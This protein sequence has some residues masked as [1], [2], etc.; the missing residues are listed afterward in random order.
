M[1][2]SFEGHGRQRY[3][4]WKHFIVSE[5]LSR[6]KGPIVLQA[7]LL[8]LGSSCNRVIELSC[9][10]PPSSISNM[11]IWEENKMCIFF[12]SLRSTLTLT[13]YFPGVSCFLLQSLPVESRVLGV[14]KAEGK[15]GWLLAGC[16]L[17]A[18]GCLLPGQNSSVLGYSFPQGGNTG[19]SG[20]CEHPPPLLAILQSYT[21]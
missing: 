12:C 13:C 20:F 15:A 21:F 7:H 14:P 1:N 16:W 5:T 3:L 18:A 9:F 10:S 17:H 6:K 8:Q 2:L 19:S 11:N 4:W